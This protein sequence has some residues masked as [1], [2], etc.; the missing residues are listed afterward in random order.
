M[1]LFNKPVAAVCLAVASACAQAQQATYDFDIP[2]QPLGEVL[3]ALARKTGLQP[4]FAENTAKGAQSP[5]VKGRFSPR[6]ALDKALAGTGLTYQF[7]GRQ[8][9]GANRNYRL[10][11]YGS[12]RSR[13]HRHHSNS[14]S[15][16]ESPG[17]A[18][19]LRSRW[20]AAPPASSASRAG[21]PAR[22]GRA[23][24]GRFVSAPFPCKPCRHHCDIASHAASCRTCAGRASRRFPPPFRACPVAGP[25]RR[26]GPEVNREEAGSFA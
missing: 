18:D 19:P 21:R 20:R 15:L 10:P 7:T 5:C 1:Y 8:G 11:G 25:A 3:D 12:C 24:K 16:I 17:R 23:R 26:S 13:G 14:Q 4:F 6:E 9:G 2:A 22:S